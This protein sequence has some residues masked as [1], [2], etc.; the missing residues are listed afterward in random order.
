[1]KMGLLD[2]SD[3]RAPC[4]NL[5]EYFQDLTFVITNSIKMSK[6]WPTIWYKSKH[7]DICFP[8][9]VMGGIMFLPNIT[10]A[11][12]YHSWHPKHI[13]HLVWL[14]ANV[15][16]FIFWDPPLGKCEVDL[17]LFVSC[18][19]R[20]Y[21]KFDVVRINFVYMVMNTEISY[22]LKIDFDVVGVRF[23]PK[24]RRVVFLSFLFVL[25]LKH[26]QNQVLSIFSLEVMLNLEA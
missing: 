2:T 18:F 20:I 24:G 14:Q 4:S 23:C 16:Q 13:S 26:R 21:E 11:I 8:F 1:M 19:V 7:F 5:V 10:K 3:E 6:F 15:I 17:I 9:L 22:I 25:Y 12:Q